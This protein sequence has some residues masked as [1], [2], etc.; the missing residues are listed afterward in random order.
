MRQS[1]LPLSNYAFHSDLSCLRP[2]RMFR[3]TL[4][5]NVGYLKV[6]SYLGHRVRLDKFIQ[7]FINVV[8]LVSGAP[9]L[10]LFSPSAECT[11]SLRRSRQS[12]AG[13]L[14][15]LWMRS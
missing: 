11:N 6:F 3:I 14:T 10:S 12:C 9:A 1:D 13:T 8:E 2:S 7:P 5:H 4:S 15:G